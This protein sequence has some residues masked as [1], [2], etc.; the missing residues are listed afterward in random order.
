[1]SIGYLMMADHSG[2]DQKYRENMLSLLG[3]GFTDFHKNLALLEK[4]KNNMEEACQKL[5][6]AWMKLYVII[7]YKLIYKYYISER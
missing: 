1:M 3:M 7:I 6:E 2:M 5:F 4:S